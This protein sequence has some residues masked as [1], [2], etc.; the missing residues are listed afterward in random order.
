[1]VRLLQVQRRQPLLIAQLARE[2]LVIRALGL[3]VHGVEDAQ[4]L[5]PADLSELR[6][7]WASFSILDDFENALRMERAIERQHFHILV[8]NRARRMEA[9]GWADK[10]REM[11]DLEPEPAWHHVWRTWAQ[12]PL[13]PWLWADHD[14]AWSLNHWNHRIDAARRA[15]TRSWEDAAFDI[16][17]L[18]VRSGFLK[19]V[20]ME[21]VET[22]GLLDR[23][24]CRFSLGG[25]DLFPDHHYFLTAFRAETARRIAVAALQVHG[26]RREH[27]RWPE[28]LDEAW[29]DA[30]DAHGWNLVDPM[31]GQPLRYRALPNDT[32][33]LLYSVG[34]DGKD[35]GGSVRVEYK[36]ETFRTLFDGKDWVWPRVAE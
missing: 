8:T 12:E 5:S 33:F 30:A 28:R 16:S 17:A 27:G 22:P 14:M 13:W 9:F 1:M 15:R 10:S 36:N 18:D 29:A 7:A 26:F 6:D 11:M 34:T 25:P 32:G 20:P 2:N 3:S 19:D 31:S 24:R 23:I 4:F 35:D 21:G